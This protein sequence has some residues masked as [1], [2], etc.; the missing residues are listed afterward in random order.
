M[1]EVEGDL[2]GSGEWWIVVTM[3]CFDGPALSILYW[4]S[5]WKIGR[6]SSS[7]GRGIKVGLIGLEGD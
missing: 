5:I 3:Y 6:C 2:G 4:I 7:S 1:N